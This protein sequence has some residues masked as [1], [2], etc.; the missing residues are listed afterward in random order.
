M[1]DERKVRTLQNNMKIEF[2]RGCPMHKGLCSSREFTLL[3]ADAAGVG[4]KDYDCN[5]WH[6]HFVCGEGHKF[7]L[8]ATLT[9]E[10]DQWDE[11]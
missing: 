11:D 1:H 6:Y 4:F 8:D 10:G 7:R 3:G 5:T 9:L 2:P